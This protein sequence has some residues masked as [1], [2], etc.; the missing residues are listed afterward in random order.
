MA[1]KAR[2]RLSSS[3]LVVPTI[4]DGT[5]SG[6]RSHKRRPTVSRRPTHA[7]VAEEDEE[8][9]K[10][11]KEVVKVVKEEVETKPPPKLVVKTG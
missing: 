4:P 9:E 7:R 11:D 6:G 2:N 3:Q 1:R 8:K 5:D 10:E